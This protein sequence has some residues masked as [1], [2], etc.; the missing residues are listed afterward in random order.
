M[1]VGAVLAVYT[2]A[3]LW[4]LYDR[5]INDTQARFF[6]IEGIQEL[7]EV[8]K[9]IFGRNKER[10]Q[11]VSSSNPGQP[12]RDRDL[13]PARQNGLR[14]FTLIDTLTL[15]A[16]EFEAITPPTAVVACGRERGFVRSLLCSYNASVNTFTKEIVLRMPMTVLDRMPKMKFFRFTLR[17]EELESE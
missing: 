16:I 11:W 6:G 2:P 4:R 3:L 13:S 5:D 14:H 17:S 8:E 10:L 9:H 1:V 12:S 7:S 15:S